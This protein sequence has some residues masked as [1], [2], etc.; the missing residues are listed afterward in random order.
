MKIYDSVAA[1]VGHTPLVALARVGAEAAGIWAGLPQNAARNLL[2]S[3]RRGEPVLAVS[4]ADIY[5]I[6]TSC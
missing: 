6:L 3:G 2:Q 5:L 4:G 1:T